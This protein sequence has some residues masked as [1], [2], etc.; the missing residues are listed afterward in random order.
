M[1]PPRLLFA[2]PEGRV[3]DHPILLAAARHGDAL[4]EPDETPIPLPPFGRIALLPGRLPVGVD[5]DDGELVVLDEVE[6]E[7]RV[8]QPVAVGALLQPGYTR[9]LLPADE[10]LPDAPTLPQWAYTAAGWGEE[11][12]V[13]WAI[14]TDERD[15][16]DPS[17]FSTPELPDLVR[18]R[19]LA[20]AENRILRQ[21]KVC[22]LEYRCFTAQNTFYCRDEGAIPASVMCNASCVGCIS[23]QPEDGP[24]SSHVRM[25]DA[26]LAEEMARVGIHHLRHATGRTMIS[27]GQGCEGEPLTR[28]KAIERAIRLMREATDRGSINI[29]TNGSLTKGLDALFRAGLDAVRIS[30][31][32]ALEPLYRAYYR[33]TGYSLR[34]VEASIAVAKE[35]GGY[36]A[37]NLLLFPGVTDREGEVDALCELVARYQV[38][39]VQT[40][41]LCI[42]P[43]QYLAVAREV[44]APG[45]PIGVPA[46]IERL[47]QARPGLAIGN[48][49]MGLEERGV[50]PQGLRT[51][52]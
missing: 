37:L 39:Q 47:R 12:M 4:G 10:P 15:H 16:W 24:P 19:L 22:A 9:T 13:A 32:S 44:A 41:S 14:R 7:G 42:D 36:V 3:Y 1:N 40:R 49:A 50:A 38:D 20:D 21:L 11:G 17:R 25:D 46:L 28:W 43:Q 2:D 45:D 33:P 26:P 35:R 30:L 29:N 52:Q 34:D 31:N 23:Q 5:P 6:V 8:F 18:A 48:F 51:T 27:F